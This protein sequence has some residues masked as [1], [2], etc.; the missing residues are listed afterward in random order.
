MTA[1]L[2]DGDPTS[3]IY[4]GEGSDDSDEEPPVQ[5][6]NVA[7]GVVDQTL[8]DSASEETDVSR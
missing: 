4:S 2:C 5:R 8:N 6:M 1:D 7:H 3:P